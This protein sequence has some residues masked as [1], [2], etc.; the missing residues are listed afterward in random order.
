MNCKCGCGQ[1]VKE[2]K[3]FKHGH[4][5]RTKEGKEKLHKKKFRNAKSNHGDG[6]L[7][8]HSEIGKAHS[9]EHRVVAGVVGT[10]K[11]IH[12][13]DGN[14]SNNEITNLLILNNRGEHSILHQQERAIA[15]CGNKTWRKCAF[16]GEYDDPKNLYIPPT[17]GTI[18]H[19]KCGNEYR[20]NRLLKI[21]NGEW[22]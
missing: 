8:C 10:E 21:K 1:K 9:L 11:I 19:R 12:H 15:A 2:G 16:C 5:N 17:R 18:E 6:Y 22:R 13:I 4:W 7:T 14:R 20:K 3:D